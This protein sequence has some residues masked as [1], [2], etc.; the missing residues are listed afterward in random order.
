MIE[1][2]RSRIIAW[3]RCPR[4]RYL[5]YHHLG[6]GLQRRAKA[7]PLQFGSAFHEG[8]PLLLTGQGIESAVLK[9]RLYLSNAFAAGEIG[10][11]GEIPDDARKALEYGME[12]QAALAEALLRGWWAWEGESFLEAFEVIECE[13]EGRAKLGEWETNEFI[14]PYASDKKSEELVLLFRPDALLRERLSG[15]LYVV[16]WKTCAT[17]T[18]RTVDQARHDMQS[19]SEVWGLTASYADAHR[20]SR[21]ESERDGVTVVS[22][23]PPHIEGVLYKFMVKGKRQ[24]DDW[25]GLYKQD[26]PLIYAWKRVGPVDVDGDEWAWRYSWKTEELNSATGKLKG[27]SLGKGWKKVPVWSEYPGGVRQWI[28]DLKHQRIAPRHLNALQE[29]FPQSMPVERRADEVQ[30]WRDQTVAQELDVASKVSDVENG[31]GDLPLLFP[32]YTHSCHSYSGCPF[33]P[34]CWEG[35]A[36]EPGELYQIRLSNHPEKEDSD[37]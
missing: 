4:E 23:I 22:A 18:K 6:K 11:D 8:T 5:A 30:E 24:K 7:L 12:E 1:T 15:D 20:A 36:A 21:R 14:S 26:S 34:I 16:S 37:G 32:K 29:S 17:F 28:D 35:A 13:R 3:Q 10:F 25:D 9:A 2:D 33:I 27:T 31:I 19:M